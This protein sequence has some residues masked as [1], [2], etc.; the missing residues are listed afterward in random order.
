MLSYFSDRLLVNLGGRAKTQ[1]VIDEVGK[2]MEG[3]FK[4][5]DH[6]LLASEPHMV[7]WRNKVMWARN[8][9]VNQLGHMRSDSP[10]G[11]WSISDAG[12]K[13]LEKQKETQ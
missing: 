6:E 4:P 2:L 13:W 10:Q 7:R 8:S 5:K 1:I 9:L 11:V 3:K 12:R